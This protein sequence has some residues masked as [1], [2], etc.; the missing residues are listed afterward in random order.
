MGAS[1][2]D[3]GQLVPRARAPVSATG[4]VSCQPS[5]TQTFTSERCPQW[6]REVPSMV[7]YSSHQ[8]GSFCINL[9]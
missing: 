2:G 8:N 3:G 1:T 4:I 5:F 9:Q 7:P 6:C